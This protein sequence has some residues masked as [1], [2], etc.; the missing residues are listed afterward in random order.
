[1]TQDKERR[2][3]KIKRLWLAAAVLLVLAAVAI[4]PPLVSVSSYKSQ[5][6]RL[7][8]SSL[9]RPVRLSSVEVRLIPRPSFVLTDLSV[10][11]DPAFGAE[12]ILHANEVTASIR[13]L[14]LWKGRLEIGNVSVDEASLNL[15]RNDAGRWNVESL[16]LNV[17]GRTRAG[18]S[19]MEAHTVRH[20]PSLEATNSRIN[21][22]SGVEKLPFSFLNADLSFN[23]DSSGEWRIRLRAE[24][25][26][27]DLS[28]QQADTGVVR[29][30]AN[31][32]QAMELRQMPI[33]L[34]MDWREAQLGQLAK[35][36]L[37][38]DPGWRGRITGQLQLNGMPDAAQVTARLQAEGVHRAEFEPAVPMDFDANCGLTY[39]YSTRSVENLA[40]DSPLGNGHVHLAGAIPAEPGKPHVTI[41]LNRVPVQAGLDMLR[42]VRSGF[43]RGLEA[44]GSV[45][46]KLSY[47]EEGQASQESRTS[48][49]NRAS[50]EN[51]T[52]DRGRPADGKPR[53]LTGG[54]TV[55]GLQLSGD[56]L[57]TPIRVAKIDLEPVPDAGLRQNELTTTIAIPAGGTT[58]L[59]LNAKVSRLGYD[60]TVRGQAGIARARELAHIAGIRGAGA[61]DGLAG[62]PMG[63][64]LHA[65]GSWIQPAPGTGSGEAN[66]RKMSG[67]VTLHGA[68]WKTAYLQNHVQI[69]AATLHIE[70]GQLDWA[71]IEFTFGRVK[72]S[73]KLSM[74]EDC[75][76]AQ[77]CV[78]RFEADFDGLDAAQ[79]Q[80]AMLGA[81]TRGTVLSTLIDRL[82]IA[83]GG[84]APPPWPKAEGTIR[85]GHVAMGPVT[86]ENVTAEVR[87]SETG[88]EIT[89]LAA[90]LLGGQL[91]VSGKLEP[92]DKPKY[93]LDCT[94]AKASA[95]A[96]GGLL[97]QRWTGAS[98]DAAGKIELAGYSSKDLA[99]SA[100]GTI[101][102]EWVHG[103]AVSRPNATPVALT[104]FDA[105]SGDAEIGGGEVTVKNNQVQ[106]GRKKAAVEVRV[107]LE[108]PPRMVFGKEGTGRK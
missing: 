73:A 74:P 46:G 63:V 75:G 26:R 31:G 93:T 85:A 92:G 8:S 83:G 66:A 33:N 79:L 103:T 86:L 2:R 87:T 57:T 4:V 34:E 51:R 28:M 101:H 25:A 53:P 105:W 44:A 37:G 3:R 36:V 9:G 97:G 22:K 11:E 88:A 29:L 19:G 40:C 91:H 59:S 94:L 17:A 100:K 45:S 61:L 82:G 14:S 96:V 12:P 98:F 18:A 64:D 78:P 95:A 50:Q 15:V 70:N 81:K 10:G 106:A 7:L 99:D 39:H 24:P 47:T 69:S 84:Q 68:N 5:I 77:K 72:G 35:L 108:T 90:G 107:G 58:P 13:L 71:P 42:T 56:G 60:V 49:E 30:N 89:G 23:E 6:T 65:E 80:Q 48:Q 21:L 102:F 76:T 104:R 38:S 55:E 20:M 52:R 41:E 43:A 62:E 32:R 27:T 16:F 1:M 54:L 67:T